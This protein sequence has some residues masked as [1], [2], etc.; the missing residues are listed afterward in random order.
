MLIIILIVLLVALYVL[1]FMQQPKFGRLPKGERLERIKKSVHYSKGAFNNLKATPALTEGV[2]YISLLG[3]FLFNRNPHLRPLQELPHVKTDLHHLPIHQNILIWLGHS[4]YYMQLNGKRILVDPV[5]S[6]SASPLPGGT[7]AFLGSD[8]YK[9]KDIPAIDF[10]VITHDHWD[11]LDYS[12]LKE[13]KPKINKVICGLGVGE[14]FEHWGF[15]PKMIIEKDWYETVDLS[16]GFNITLTPARHFSGRTLKRNTS[17]W[18]SYVLQTPS[19]K[20][21]IGGDSG[22]DSHFAEIGEKYGP[23]DLAI[24][25]NGQ[26]DKNWRYIHML[27]NEFVM[28][29][30]EINAKKILPVHSSKFALGNHSWSEPLAKVTELN[31]AIGLPILTPIIGEPVYLDKTDKKYSNWWETV[32]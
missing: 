21:Y 30:R 3:E 10:L 4:S 31:K 24:L 25:E 20:I 29:A 28:A 19:L 18:V 12:S 6:G 5:L 8:I 7:K 23:F 1:H 22:Y 16:D 13:L 17:L 32:K 27:P 26:Y 11:H 9:P 2:S 14:H 15:N